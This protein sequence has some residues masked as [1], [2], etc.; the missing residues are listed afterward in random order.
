MCLGQIIAISFAMNLFFLAILLEPL[1]SSAD[2]TPCK[3]LPEFDQRTHSN[4]NL[5]SSNNRIQEQEGRM[6]PELYAHDDR[7]PPATQAHGQPWDY[8]K[9]TWASQTVIYTTLI[10]NF[11]SI[12]LIPYTAHTRFFMPMLAIPHVLLFVPVVIYNIL[13]RSRT[14]VQSFPGGSIYIFISVVSLCLYTK[15]T[16]A[17]LMEADTRNKLYVNPRRF[18]AELYTHPAVSSVG[19]DV[20]LCWS[21]ALLWAISQS[22]DKSETPEQI[23]GIVSWGGNIKALKTKSNG[24]TNQSPKEE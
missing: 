8:K 1:Q 24:R 7:A 3:P 12:F 11:L 13:P 19:W 23:L 20:I 22:I 10:L 15:A 18:M 21:S 17:V 14:Y 6:L 4:A 2:G 16:I 5:T 9:M